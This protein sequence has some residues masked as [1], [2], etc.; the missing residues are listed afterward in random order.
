[1]SE[2]SSDSESS[3]GW[4]I[5]NHEGSDIETL[6]PDHGDANADLT[7][8]HRDAFV[9]EL[10]PANPER[11]PD[12]YSNETSASTVEIF[13]QASEETHLA[14]ED[15]PPSSISM[16]ASTLP[17]E[18]FCHQKETV[19]A[20]DSRGEVTSDDSD[21]VTLETP[22]VE[23]IGPLDEMADTGD[24]NMS[25]S[26]SSQYTFSKPDAVYAPQH[27]ANETSND[28]ASDDSGPILRHRR[29]KKLSTSESGDKD[30]T[31]YS[32]PPDPGTVAR[33]GRGLN[34]CVILALVIAIS[35]GFGH[36]YGT[37]QILERQEH[38]EKINEHELSDVKED[39]VHCQKDQIATVEEQIET[40][41]LENIKTEEETEVLA[42]EN[43]YL[44]TSLKKG[45]DAFS[46]LQEELR[47][48]R[49]QIRN[50][51]EKGDGDLIKSENQKLRTYLKEERKKLRSFLTQKETLLVEAQ[52]LRKELD[53]ER[54][55]TKSLKLELEE[56][57]NRRSPDTSQDTVESSQEIEH[58]RERLFD[59]ENKLNF[60]Q[61][62]SDLWER[63]YIEAKE[64]NEKREGGNPQGSQEK[65]QSK[66]KGKKENFFNSVKDT[67]DAMK[68]STKAFV[69]HHK[70]KIKQAKEAVKENL[71]KFSDSVKTTFRQF[72]DSTKNMFDKNRKKY[73]EKRREET[74]EAHTVWRE[75]SRGSEDA[76]EK[77]SNQ[78]EYD[79]LKYDNSDIDDE[80]AWKSNYDFVN[81]V[82]DYLGDMKEY[83]SDNAGIF[84]DLDEF[85]YGHF[86][87]NAYAAPYGPRK[88]DKI[89][90][91]KHPETPRNRKEQKN[92]RNHYRR[93]GYPDP[94][95][96][97]VNKPRCPPVQPLCVPVPDLTVAC[98][99]QFGFENFCRYDFNKSKVCL[100]S[101]NLH[102][103]APLNI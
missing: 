92:Q 94:C 96:L 74:K 24:I 79:N 44:R 98:C 97:T 73:A 17:D 88:L 12:L 7:L 3:C 19:L 34:K 93:E 50:L 40:N 18:E 91:R 95:L 20:A 78:K 71:K 22:R 61:Q 25:S 100:V 62:R 36:F 51:E 52:S 37:L 56:I 53:N 54:K 48:L 55:I 21:I 76:Y 5:I 69:R 75:Y 59:L 30:D 68:N 57:S 14:S 33:Q 87:G 27:S 6:H 4:T 63:L 41:D 16:A 35:M 26:S 81:D 89:P 99:L 38:V 13:L 23:E 83:T 49:E 11:Q 46:L 90:P 39:L 86:F 64:Q 101:E 60:E 8:E 70:E 82:E 85:V 45:E 9:E 67:F 77:K 65:E 58:M 47:K 80:T 2:N 43:Q 72:K 28:E 29:S 102:A 84:E 10:E 103:A 66:T 42:M 15:V 32:T 1:M 31:E